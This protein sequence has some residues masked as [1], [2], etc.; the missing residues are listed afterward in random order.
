MIFLTHTGKQKSLDDQTIYHNCGCVIVAALTSASVV[1]MASAQQSQTS[2]S[3]FG[4]IASLQNGKDGKPEWILSGAWEF[5]SINSSTPTFNATFNMVMLDG[6]A[7]HKH[8]ITDFKMI[9]GPAKN[10]TATVSLKKG[11]VSS[12][13]ISIKLM[14]PIAMSLWID[15]TKTENHFGNTP[16]YGV[17]HGMSIQMK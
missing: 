13:P 14:G 6:N 4:T 1:Y 10:G 11:P 5:R 17:R 3:K 8:T 9:G 15:P 7:P 12:V 16:I 2:G